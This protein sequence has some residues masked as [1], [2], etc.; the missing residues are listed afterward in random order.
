MHSGRCKADQYPVHGMLVKTSAVNAASRLPSGFDFSLF[1]CTVFLQYLVLFGHCKKVVSL[2]DT[3]DVVKPQ[4]SPSIRPHLTEITPTPPSHRP[5]DEKS[6]IEVS[7]AAV[8]RN[9]EVCITSDL[10]PYG[11]IQP[12][13]CR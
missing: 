3:T 1:P 2:N 5:Q 7:G 13:T 12:V 10:V 9:P 11:A 8:Y 6:V 4:E